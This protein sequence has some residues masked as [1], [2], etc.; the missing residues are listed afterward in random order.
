MGALS[1][2]H[3]LPGQA[4]SLGVFSGLD[5]GTVS[6]NGQTFDLCLGCDDIAFVELRFSSTVILPEFTGDLMIELSAPFRAAGHTSFPNLG[7]PVELFGSGTATVDLEW[8]PEVP[9]FTG[10][11]YR[12]LCFNFE[13]AA[14]VP[15]PASLLLLGSGVAALVTQRTRRIWRTRRSDAPPR[16]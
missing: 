12:G 1:C 6:I 11:F 7:S 2:L 8:E 3:C 13:P 15:E 14:P 4:F 5:H 16:L 9:V 10:W